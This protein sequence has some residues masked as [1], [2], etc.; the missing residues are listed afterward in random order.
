M[1]AMRGR[2]LKSLHASAKAADLLF[3][4]QD[5]DCRWDK[6][7]FDHINIP[8]HLLKKALS[9]LCEGI[10]SGYSPS[11]A[12]ARHPRLICRQVSAKGGK[13]SLKTEAPLTS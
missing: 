5:P 9:S 12:D 3:E 13:R 4:E 10:G 8:R 2:A 11:G 7:H 6:R 1:Q